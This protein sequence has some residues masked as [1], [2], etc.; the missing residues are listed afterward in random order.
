MPEELSLRWAGNAGWL[1][2]AGGRLI[3]TDL[4]LHL[5]GKIDEPP[6]TATELAG[7]PTGS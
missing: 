2:E 3:A 4:D 1:I 7:R 5:A 6:V